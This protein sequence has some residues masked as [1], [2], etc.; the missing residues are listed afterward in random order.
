MAEDISARLERLGSGDYKP[1]TFLERGVAVPFTTPML[2]GARLRPSGRRAG[3]ELIITNMSRGRGFY[4]VAFSALSEICAPTLHDERLL[5]L[6][7]Q[8]HPI[9]PAL[10]REA[11][12][13]AA[14]E[15]YAGRAAAA[16]AEAAIR[17]LPEDR[18]RL[19]LLLLQ[20]LIRQT[21]TVEEAR[22]A[23]ERGQADELQDRAKR[24][25]Q[26]AAPLLEVAP[27]QILGW[28][29]ELSDLLAEIGMP[30]DPLLARIRR[31]V[32]EVEATRREAAAWLAR[33]SGSGKLGELLAEVA[34]QTLRCCAVMMEQLDAELKDPL[35]LLRR[36]R[37][38]AAGLRQL[39]GRPDW[40]LDGWPLIYGIWRDAGPDRRLAAAW[41]M[42]MLLPVLPSEAQAWCGVT[43]DWDQT[44]KRRHGVPARQD[45]ASGRPVDITARSER[46]IARV[47]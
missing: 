35:L 9:T 46:L 17:A 28:I 33:S 38:D 6:L 45:W 13:T 25:V 8:P 43:A 5:A 22:A 24:A 7:S 30:G 18:A 1:T 14:R 37:D 11:A 23:V 44:A 10:M 26:R 34:E 42:A 20:R 47:A 16:A 39:A 21:E 32:I 4:V 19:K 31:Q 2:L 15:G 29:E 41:E 12:R 36:W 40:L 27:A 3:I